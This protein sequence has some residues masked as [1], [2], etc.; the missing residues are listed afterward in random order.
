[1]FAKLFIEVLPRFCGGLTYGIERHVGQQRGRHVRRT[2]HRVAPSA[3]GVHRAVQPLHAAGYI[4]RILLAVYPLQG[5]HT[6]GRGDGTA[7]EPAIPH[8]AGC[9]ALHESAVGF[10]PHLLELFLILFIPHS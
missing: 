8:T 3:I 7:G 4:R 1:M 6:H 5:E 2:L 10:L 9:P